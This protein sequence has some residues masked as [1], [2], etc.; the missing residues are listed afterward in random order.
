MPLIECHTHNHIS[1]DAEGTLDAMC[2]SAIRAGVGTLALTNH[3]ELDAVLAGRCGAPDHLAEEQEFLA[4]KEKYAGRLTLLRGIELGQPYASLEESE[5][6]LRAR[7]YDVVLG[8]VHLLSDG[9]DFYDYEN[10]PLTDEQYRAMWEDYL[11]LLLKNASVS[12][13]D[14]QTHLTYPLRY[15]PAD[16]RERITGMPG[17]A[18]ELFEPILR[19]LVERGVALEINTAALRR[20]AALLPEPDP[21]LALL[22]RY[23]ELGGEL[24]SIGSDAHRPADVAAGLREGTRLA[25]QAGFR[26]FAVFRERKPYLVSMEEILS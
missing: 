19:K 6:L 16:R 23:R 18:V 5:R 12:P 1:F 9:T 21:G 24:L 2:D 14:V 20:P 17:R 22:K 11:G 8:S 26:Y 15:I 3:Y 10:A 13:V 7:P 25:Q 4:A